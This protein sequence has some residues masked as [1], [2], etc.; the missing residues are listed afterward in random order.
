MKIKD[1]DYP[2]SCIISRPSGATDLLGIEIMTKIY[3]GPCEIQYPTSGTNNLHSSNY[4][5]ETLLFIPV[6]DVLFEIND[7]VVVSSMN[8]RESKFSVRQ[9]ETIS[10]KSVPLNDTC[11][12]LKEGR[13]G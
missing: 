10:G 6:V 13:D 12:W 9:F 11:I 1:Y 4:Q 8:S 2:D 7:Q 5:S 3:S